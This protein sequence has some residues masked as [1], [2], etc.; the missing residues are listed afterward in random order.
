MCIKISFLPGSH[1]PDSI[2]WYV[3]NANGDLIIIYLMRFLLTVTKLLLTYAT[4]LTSISARYSIIL[5]TSVL[6][7]T[8]NNSTFR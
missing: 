1:F 8:A 3:E 2:I 4:L 6:Y 5:L 7:I